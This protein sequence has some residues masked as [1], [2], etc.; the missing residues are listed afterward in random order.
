[1]YGKPMICFEI[2]ASLSLNVNDT[3]IELNAWTLE[4]SLSFKV[5]MKYVELKF[6]FPLNKL[7]YAELPSLL[8]LVFSQAYFSMNFIEF[9]H[10]GCIAHA[11][12]IIFA[13]NLFSAITLKMQTPVYCLKSKNFAISSNFYIYECHLYKKLIHICHPL[14]LLNCI[15]RSRSN[16]AFCSLICR[17]KARR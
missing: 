11:L 2:N 12:K 3:Q 17:E 7:Y 15:L 1:M 14:I 9:Y 10:F 16:P 4:I 6:L 8:I 13:Y 5:R